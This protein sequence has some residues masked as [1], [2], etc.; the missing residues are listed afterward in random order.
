MMLRL[1]THLLLALVFINNGKQLNVRIH[2]VVI[3]CPMVTGNACM[4]SDTGSGA[5]AA[6]NG[7]SE[8]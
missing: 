2:F 4:S 1:L 3:K 6:T 7:P 5:T 8:T